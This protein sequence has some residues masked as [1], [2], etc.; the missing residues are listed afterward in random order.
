MPQ[1]SLN[2]EKEQLEH[3]DGAAGALLFDARCLFDQ[4]EARADEVLRSIAT[5]LPEAVGTCAAAAA[6]D[7]S[8]ARQAALLKVACQL[9]THL[10][11]SKPGLGFESRFCVSMMSRSPD[12]STCHDKAMFTAIQHPLPS[13]L[14]Q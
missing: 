10:G 3:A 13:S 7:H 4:E 1:L 9:D 12:K 5:D 14:R 11:P 2:G 8:P 6:A